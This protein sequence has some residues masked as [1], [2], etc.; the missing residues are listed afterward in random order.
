MRPR[1]RQARWGPRRR[2]DAGGRSRPRSGA[3]ADRHRASSWPSR[4]PGWRPPGWSGASGR[5]S[6]LRPPSPQI[7]LV[8]LTVA[9]LAA[10]RLWPTLRRFVETVD[11]RALMLFHLTRFVG[12]YFLALHARGELPW[13]FAVPGGWGDIVVA[14]SALLLVVVARP[15]TPGG[16]PRLSRVE[17]GRPGRHHR[18]R[19]DRGPSRVRGSRVD[20]RAASSPALA[21]PHVR[22]ADRHRDARLDAPAAGV[23]PTGTLRGGQAHR[24]PTPRSRVFSACLLVN[25]CERRRPQAVWIPGRHP[26]ASCHLGTGVLPRSHGPRNAPRADPAGGRSRHAPPDR[27]AGRAPT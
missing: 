10:E 21:P 7:I 14:A 27:H 26:R 2:T 24:C 17:R 3:A 15:D 1:R 11:L 5:L 13:A 18:G 12:F 20:A 4:A 19:P 8:G 23:P 6:T 25:R 22:R 16:P 9:L